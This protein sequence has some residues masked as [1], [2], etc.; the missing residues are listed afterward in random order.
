MHMDMDMNVDV[1]DQVLVDVD[2]DDYF[3]SFL[4]AMALVCWLQAL[5][6][7]LEDIKPDHREAAATALGNLRRPHW[8]CGGGLPAPHHLQQFDPAPLAAQKNRYGRLAR[9]PAA[10]F[11]AA[12]AAAGSAEAAGAA[13][14]AAAA[15]ARRLLWE[16]AGL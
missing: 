12:P 6:S 1:Y 9:S 15:G 4:I 8:L 5:R 14:A 16:G 13:K 11:V 7:L 3:M 2:V 10:G